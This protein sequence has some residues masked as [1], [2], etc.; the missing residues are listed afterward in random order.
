MANKMT[1]Y[2]GKTKTEGNGKQKDAAR[3]KGRQPGRNDQHRP[4]GAA[5]LH[6]H[7]RECAAYYKAGAS[8]RPA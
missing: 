5:G 2:F 7:D 1:Y 6:D 8:C 4:A 3:R